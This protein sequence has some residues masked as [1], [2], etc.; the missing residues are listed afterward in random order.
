M[1][2]PILDL[3][4]HLPIVLLNHGRVSGGNCC[5]VSE[6]PGLLR[7][8]AMAK[9]VEASHGFRVAFL[10]SVYYETCR[11]SAIDFLFRVHGPGMAQAFQ[12]LIPIGLVLFFL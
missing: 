5:L 12:A 6:T 4:Y 7:K 2:R 8:E 9:G 3:F 11:D 1:A 10:P